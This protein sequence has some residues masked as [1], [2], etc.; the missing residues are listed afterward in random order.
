MGAIEQTVHEFAVGELRVLGA[1]ILKGFHLS[2]RGR[3]TGEIEG[4]TPD[5][6]GGVSGWGGAEILG[7]EARLDEGI[8]FSSLDFLRWLK[9]PVPFVFGALF[10]PGFQDVT[11]L[12]GEGWLVRFGGRHDLVL[13]GTDDALPGV[14]FGEIT[15]DDAMCAIAVFGGTFKSVKPETA[16]SV[17]GVKTVAGITIFGKD[18]TD[19]AVEADPAN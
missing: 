4:N 3:E 11:L 8:N 10:D 2:W 12:L 19:I 13:V 9:G 6:S 17:R 16:F 18:G 5:E 7:F 15:W 1:R 14:G